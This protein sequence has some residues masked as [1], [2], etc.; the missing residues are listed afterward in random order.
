MT[1]TNSIVN[2][3]QETALRLK[4]TWYDESIAAEEFAITTIFLPP[5]QWT[6][7]TMTAFL[8]S[9]LPTFANDPYPDTVYGLGGTAIPLPIPTNDPV[10]KS[11]LNTKFIFTQ[12]ASILDQTFAGTV[13]RH[14]YR[15][16]ELVNDEASYRLFVLLG[17]VKI[18]NPDESNALRPNFII[19]VTVSSRVF[20]GVN[21]T[22]TYDVVNQIESTYSFDFTATHSLYLYTETPINSQFRSP[23][24]QNNPSNLLA[25]IPMNVPFGFQFT[26][27]P[28]NVV[29]SQQKNLNV[30][31]L[32]VTIRDD[33][34]E[35]VDF[36]NLPYHIDL[37]FKFGQSED[38]I[39]MSGQE[40]VAPVIANAPSVHATAASYNNP[41]ARDVLF[42][43]SQ[44]NSSSVTGSKRVKSSI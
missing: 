13:N 3:P 20:D 1:G 42:G 17:L 4:C 12:Y 30:S 23:F 43:G 37:S 40:G 38:T 26:Y 34:G 16:F 41:A 8:N 21:T 31:N 25:R 14:I 32:Q 24:N 29:Y 6:Y 28:N 5:G 35:F 10:S 39:R 22:M 11:E 18:N 44:N 9:E 2:L 15:T 27:Q 19:R 7:S 36:Q 33:Y